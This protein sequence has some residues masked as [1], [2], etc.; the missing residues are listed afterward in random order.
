MCN[1][2]SKKSSAKSSNFEEDDKPLPPF[3]SY[4]SVALSIS[5]TSYFYLKGRLSHQIEMGSKG[6]MVKGTVSRDDFCSEFFSSLELE[7]L[8]NG[9]KYYTINARFF[10]KV[11]ADLKEKVSQK[12]PFIILF[13]SFTTKNWWQK[14]TW[15]C[16]FQIFRL[17]RLFL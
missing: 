15:N 12:M 3:R 11:Y 4:Y 10:K 6:Y 5:T 8:S 14:S 13:V 2:K 9:L 1:A 7:P 17:M 16:L